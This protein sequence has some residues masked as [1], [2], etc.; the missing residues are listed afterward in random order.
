MYRIMVA[1]DEPKVRRG[2][3]NLVAESG[4]PL[5]ICAQA[6]TGQEALQHLISH[7]PDIVLL[8]I[9]M[10]LMDGLEFLMEA[11]RLGIHRKFIIL[12]GFDKFAFAQQSVALQAYAYLLKPIDEAELI[13]YIRK[14]ID[15]LD[16]EKQLEQQHNQVVTQLESNKTLLRNTFLSSWIDGIL[17][18][19]ELEQG[20][21]FWAIDLPTS[22]WVIVLKPDFERSEVIHN[23]EKS[24]MVFGASNIAEELLKPCQVSICV[25]NDKGYSAI[26]TRERPTAAQ[27]EALKATALQSLQLIVNVV[28][29]NIFSADELPVAIEASLK[30]ILVNTRKDPVIAQIQ[31][32]LS[33]HYKDQNTSLS[34]LSKAL[35]V[36]K[37]Q[38]ARIFKSAFVTTYTNYLTE[39]RMRKAI[40]LMK[41]KNNK[42]SWIAIEVGYSNLHYFSYAFKKYTGQSPSAF[43]ECKYEN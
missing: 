18:A 42:L 32:Y 20:L 29:R 33:H 15:D 11:K 5:E 16:S 28:C 19:Q 34:D 24:L 40:D 17:T 36:S 27:I 3:C 39:V 25:K 4:L 37:A 38:L 2:L 8:D 22:P 7:Q 41:F 10:P 26:I 21:S 6:S 31:E 9:C 43:R 35:S 1:D 23:Q 13:H 14:A 12:T 30:E